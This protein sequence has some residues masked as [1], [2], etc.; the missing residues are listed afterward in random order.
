M[1][2]PAEDFTIPTDPELW[3]AFT[4]HIREAAVLQGPAAFQNRATKYSGTGG[5]T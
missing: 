5:K 1:Q 3:G 4:D 2:Q